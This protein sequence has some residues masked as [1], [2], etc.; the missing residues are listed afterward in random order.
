[1]KCMY[2]DMV[3]KDYLW[4][5]FTNKS[6]PTERR[7]RLNKNIKHHKLPSAKNIQKHQT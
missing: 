2:C 1:M 5:I 4:K 6:A 3:L 7:F